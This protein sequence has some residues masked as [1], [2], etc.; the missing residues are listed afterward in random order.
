MFKASNKR[1]SL[2]NAKEPVLRALQKR[3]QFRPRTFLQNPEILASEDREQRSAVFGQFH[4]HKV[5]WQAR[6][7]EPETSLPFANVLSVICTI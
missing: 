3:S 1:S 7:S 5:G 6:Q 2:F 4:G